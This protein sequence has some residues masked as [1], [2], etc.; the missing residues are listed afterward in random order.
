MLSPTCTDDEEVS[1]SPGIVPIEPGL[2]ARFKHVLQCDALHTPI[3]LSPT[4]DAMPPAWEQ[5]RQIVHAFSTRPF[6]ADASK[7]LHLACIL[8]LRPRQ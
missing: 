3:F 7:I 2:W 6:A 8:V 1:T 4:L 5:G